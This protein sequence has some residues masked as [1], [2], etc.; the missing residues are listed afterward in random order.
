MWNS[1]VQPLLINGQ[2]T[3]YMRSIVDQVFSR[4]DINMDGAL[5]LEEYNAIERAAG[6]NVSPPEQIAFILQHLGEQIWP[7]FAT[8]FL[9]IKKGIPLLPNRCLAKE[10]YVSLC[11]INLYYYPAKTKRSLI[12]LGIYVPEASFPPA[13]PPQHLQV[14]EASLNLY[15]EWSRI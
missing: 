14:F 9:T 5:S 13:P 11:A 15:F 12:N 4:F 3:P 8:F 7:I 10:G 1:P 6:E 2:P